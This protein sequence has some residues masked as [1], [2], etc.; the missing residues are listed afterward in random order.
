MEGHS[1]FVSLLLITILAALVPV[2]SNRLGRFQIPL[3]VCEIVA[4]MIIGRS[5]LN[6]VH[7]TPILS[8]LA[9]FGFTFLMFLSGL[10]V[11]I[12]MLV[13]GV[14][15]EKTS[16]LRRPATLA[17][18]HFVATVLLAIVIGFALVASGFAHSGI[19]MGLILSTTSL[20]IV[21][22]ILKERGLTP[23]KY[24]QVILVAA[25]ISDFVT[26]LL[27]S[28][29]IAVLSKGL[30]LDLLLILVLAAAFVL[31]AKIGQWARRIPMLPRLLDE[32]SHATAQFRVRG[33][34]ALMVI[35]VVLAES[36][37][38]EVILG[39]F[40][41]GAIVSVS[42]GSHESPMREK[43]DA[44]GYGFFIPIFFINVGAEF[45]VGALL[46]SGGALLLVP[47]LIVSAFA[48]KLVP[49]ALFRLLFPWRET[50]AAGLL[51]SSRLSLIIATSAVA[52]NL[53]IISAA[54][55]SAIILVAISTCT[56]S[57]ILF[58]RVLP[59][60]VS[61]KREGVIIL[62]TDQLAM[63]LGQRLRKS[64][65]KTTFVGRDQQ[66]IEVLAQSDFSGIAG[67][68]QDV[69]V[70]EKAG[71]ANAKALIAVTNDAALIVTVAGLAKGQFQVPLVIARADDPQTVQRLQG[72]DVRVVQPAMAVALALE[73]ALHFP[74]A[75]GM[76]MDKEDNVDIVDVPLW[77]EAIAGQPLRRVRLPGNALVLG[78]HRQGEVVVPHGDT[79]V[80][81]GDIL[82]LLGSSDALREARLSLGGGS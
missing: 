6:L 49:A 37:G 1:T 5:G 64:G 73:G 78:V 16:F 52:M 77:N 70:L 15:G 26:L 8:F 66:Q 17:G 38:V 35:W 28:I 7:P 39:A 80:K 11:D 40:L 57:P 3:V 67:N 82:V 4:G 33:A 76:L 72:M 48:V 79:V 53:G 42:S 25:L 45:N 51:L 71:I 18:I 20:G 44:I 32:I 23:T 34:L 41:A 10:E 50:V 12:D 81:R 65:E 31:G 21:V 36:L 54:T 2:V 9:E 56:L 61:A 59:K 24:G 55:N 14:K 22:P 62:G 47:L 19:L 68:P 27:L 58:A 69:S 46:E 30:S 60:R 43:L 29:A 74:S 13:R 63:L 75:F